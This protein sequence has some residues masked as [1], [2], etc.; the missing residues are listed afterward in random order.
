MCVCARS[1]NI[2]VFICVENSWDIE[3]GRTRERK[4]VEIHSNRGLVF[5]SA[6]DISSFQQSVSSWTSV[7][8]ST[9]VTTPHG[10]EKLEVI[11]FTFSLLLFVSLVT[12]S[13]GRRCNKRV[14]SFKGVTIKCRE[15]ESCTADAVTLF[16][17][18]FHQPVGPF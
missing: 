2:V 3:N 1:T 6:R 14:N 5:F 15:D 9:T 4:S 17:G 10:D 11:S 13:A 7:P 12:R 16:S 8:F 18:P